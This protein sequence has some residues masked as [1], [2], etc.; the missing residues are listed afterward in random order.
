MGKKMCILAFIGFSL[1]VSSE[2]FIDITPHNEANQYEMKLN[3]SVTFKVSGY[4]QEGDSVSN[5][6]VEDK[7][8]WEFDKTLLEKV[9]S[10]KTSLTLKAIKE[11]IAELCA[12]TLIKNNHCQKKINISIIK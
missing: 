10:D 12:T 7:I 11:G 8:W 6:A 2:Y 1:C 3:D 4:A 5:A 9:S